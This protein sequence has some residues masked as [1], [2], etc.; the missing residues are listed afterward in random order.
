M[1]A[2]GAIS[3]LSRRQRVTAF[4]TAEAEWVACGEAVR[5]A[6]WIRNLRRELGYNDGKTPV[7]LFTDNQAALALT[8]NPVSHAR[9]KQIDVVGHAIRDHV[10]EGHVDFAYVPTAE[11]TADILTKPLGPQQFEPKRDMLGVRPCRSTVA[12]GGVLE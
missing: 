5:E 3:Y 8:Q 7:H 2:G 1:S 4:A 9:T 12:A 11:N 6:L 10:R